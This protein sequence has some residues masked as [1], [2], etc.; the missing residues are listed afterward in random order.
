MMLNDMDE[1]LEPENKKDMTGIW[2]TLG[3]VG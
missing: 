1:V 2:I 3:C